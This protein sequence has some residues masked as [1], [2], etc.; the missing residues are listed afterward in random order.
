[1]LR[2]GLVTVGVLIAILGA[3]ALT[4]GVLGPSVAFLIWGCVLVA[5]LLFE[6][7]RYKR[8]AARSPGPGWERTT[9]RFV[10]EETGKMVTVYVQ[11]G[12][13]ERVYVQE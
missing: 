10:D 5:A 4:S 12:T 9:E 6:R 7:F 3:A 11:P 13:G 1:M 2:K 8:L